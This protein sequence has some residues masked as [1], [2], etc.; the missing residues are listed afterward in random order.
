MMLAWH[1]LLSKPAAHNRRVVEASAGNSDA[2][3]G[4]PPG[5]G[6]PSKG[7][8]G[9]RGLG[10]VLAGERQCLGPALV[11][12]GFHDRWDLGVGEEAL[13]ALL[14]PVEDHPDPV[15]LSGIAKDEGTLGPMLLA[16]LSAFGGEG[17]PEAVEIVDLRRCQDHVSHPPWL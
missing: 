8:I 15:V 9:G 11:P 10:I 16:L 3:R 13:P 2:A 7:P 5:G 1:A 6:P 4:C 12:G 14:I 17:I